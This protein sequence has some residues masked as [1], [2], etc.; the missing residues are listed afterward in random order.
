MILGLL[1]D[2]TV[3]VHLGFVVFVVLGG[4]LVIRRREWVV[5]H[6]PAALWGAAVELG[7]W[8][9]PLTPLE[10]WLR[11]GAGE[12][13][14]RGGFVEHYIVSLLYPPG[15]TR[16]VQVT[17]GIAVLAVNVVFYGIAWGRYRSTRGRG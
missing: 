9:C 4:L 8:V 14:Y 2:A 3:I 6:L 1:A 16:G 15:L 7:G 13:G 12:A 10:N 11:E 5:L 17:L